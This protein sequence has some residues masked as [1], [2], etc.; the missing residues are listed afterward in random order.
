MKDLG[1]DDQIDKF[2]SFVDDVRT[3]IG[4]L[5]AISTRLCQGLQINFNTLVDD[6][7]ITI[8]GLIDKFT[9]FVSDIKTTISNLIPGWMKGS[10][11]GNAASGSEEGFIKFIRETK[12]GSENYDK[13]AQL[14]DEVLRAAYR[15]GLT[16]VPQDHENLAKPHEYDI[17][18]KN[19]VPEYT[20]SIQNNTTLNT[21]NNANPLGDLGAA[22]NKAPSG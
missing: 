12:K 22:A 5:K 4:D 8:T 21:T 19:A 11:S 6:I 18:V 10:D 13:Y 2:K 16:G 3:S 20:K 1:I 15:E 17:I 7:K 14:S 9:T